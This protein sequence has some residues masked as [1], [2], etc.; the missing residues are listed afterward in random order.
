MKI[1]HILLAALFLLAS[2]T[3]EKNTTDVGASRNLSVN[4]QS[5][6]DSIITDTLG[7]KQ[8]LAQLSKKPQ[9]FSFDA[10]ED[11]TIV[12]K[13]GTKITIAANSLVS[14]KTGKP[15]SGKVCLKLTEYYKIS[16][17]LI[18]NLS[19]TSD[20][21]LLETGGMINVEAYANGEK[22]KLKDGAAADVVFPT[23]K[24]DDEMK[25]FNGVIG[26]NGVINWKILVKK[27]VERKTEDEVLEDIEPIIIIN[28]RNIKDIKVQ[29][30]VGVTSYVPTKKEAKE[31]SDTVFS[32]LK[33]GWLNSDRF[34]CRDK[35]LITF[36]IKEKLPLES[37]VL[38]VCK[39]FQGVFN[40]I[41]FEGGRFGFSDENAY[42]FKLIPSNEPVTIIIFK[43]VDGIN[44]IAIKDALTTEEGVSGFVFK[45]FKI[46]ELKKLL[47]GLDK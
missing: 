46:T 26:K 47:Q 17:M 42:T 9:S 33:L 6:T 12:G 34:I 41:S 32:S 27:D 21:K 25:L 24:K 13:E 37:E 22:L 29:N 18:A 14:E 16:D 23:R 36:I 39:N 20:G 38:I 35:Q 28:K 2:C 5:K 11:K 40:S 31:F 4:T 10:S 3:K 43:K 15:V 30:N 45:S 19:T 7:I 44:Y 8:V 1:I